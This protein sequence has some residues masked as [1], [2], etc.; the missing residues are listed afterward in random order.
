MPEG[1]TGFFA[2]A[3]YYIYDNAVSFP[4][5]PIIGS[6]AD[7]YVTRQQFHYV[8]YVGYP[9][10]WGTKPIPLVIK[11]R[12]GR[13]PTDKDHLNTYKLKPNYPAISFAEG[14]DQAELDYTHQS[15]YIHK[16]I[17][18]AIWSSVVIRYMG[19]YPII[20]YDALITLMKTWNDIEDLI[21]GT[22]VMVWKI[23]G[24]IMFAPILPIWLTWDTSL[25]RPI[26]WG[27]G[28]LSTTIMMVSGFLFFN[29]II[30]TEWNEKF[31]SVLQRWVNKG[32]HVR[33]RYLEVKRNVPKPIRYTSSTLALVI[34]F[35]LRS[36]LVIVSRAIRTAFIQ[37]TTWQVLNGITFTIPG[38]DEEAGFNG[39]INQSGNAL[40][41]DL[42][43]PI[44][45]PETSPTRTI[46]SFGSSSSLTSSTGTTTS[47]S[48]KSSMDMDWKLTTP[49]LMIGS[50]ESL[51]ELYERDEME[52]EREMLLDSS[53]AGG[54]DSG[55]KRTGFGRMFF[56]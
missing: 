42:G 45:S 15:I 52:R 43:S 7:L 24:G 34:E 2:P 49:K 35:L 13:K 10:V 36:L 19:H 38:N 48:S 1:D 53:K 9:P 54:Y 30:R 50:Y 28:L 4:D 5:S 39:R 32:Q 6:L 46:M 26:I 20:W 40:G 22:L 8:D 11:P 12:E 51:D 14:L 55:N 33:N 23:L 31:I 27:Y 18:M 37:S 44:F 47:H 41:L 16:L 29:P 21:Q 17:G 3:G 56:H 25:L